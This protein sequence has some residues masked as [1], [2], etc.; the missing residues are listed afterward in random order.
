MKIK[1]TKLPNDLNL[2]RI[3]KKRMAETYRRCPYCYDKTF[4]KHLDE[5]KPPRNN[6][7]TKYTEDDYKR[8]DE[9]SLKDVTGM[10]HL[11]RDNFV[12]APIEKP[13]PGYKGNLFKKNKKFTWEYIHY[14]C[15]NCGIEWDSPEFPVGFSDDPEIINT[16][17]ENYNNAKE[18]DI[19]TFLIGCVNSTKG[20]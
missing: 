7:E 13:I 8:A 17:F 4:K 3:I 2:D 9:L 20:S 12:G 15:G 19:N 18:A 6:R 10:Y 14:K 16:I 5:I 1:I 11:V